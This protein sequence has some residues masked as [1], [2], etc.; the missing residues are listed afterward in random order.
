MIVGIGTD[1]VEIARI[2]SSV[3][4]WGEKFA[5]KILSVSELS[6]YRQRGNAAYLAKRFAAKEAVSK[7]LGT[8]MRCGVGFTQIEVVGQP[9]YPPKIVLSGAAAG[10]AQRLGVRASHL[11]LSD[12]REYAIAYVLLES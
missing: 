7:A 11:S 12:E 3:R 5:M 9:G 6:Q 8:G 4:R 2:E 10:H 1:I